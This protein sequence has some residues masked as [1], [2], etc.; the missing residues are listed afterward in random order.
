VR[1]LAHQLCWR[2]HET[3]GSKL[4]PTDCKGCHTGVAGSEEQLKARLK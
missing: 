1:A 2:C 3:S 4:A